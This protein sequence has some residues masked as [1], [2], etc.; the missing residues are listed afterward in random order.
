M[1]S[2]TQRGH[3]ATPSA[4][5]VNR[6]DKAVAGL[7]LEPLTSARGFSRETFAL[8]LA[9]Q[10]LLWGLGVPLAG[11]IADRSGAVSVMVVGALLYAVG[12]Y[13][14]ADVTSP[15]GLYLAAGVVTGIP[16]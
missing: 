10:N 6:A 7:F 16:A 14:M 15:T 8:A 5:I 9:W 11:A 2:A 4:L 12:L 13:T 3:P 1:A